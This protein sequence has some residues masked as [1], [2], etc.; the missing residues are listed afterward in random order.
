LHLHHGTLIGILLPH[1]L[2]FN[3]AAAEAEIAGIRHAASIPNAVTTHDWMAGFASDLGLPLKLSELGV[4]PGILPEIA[5][6]AA[7][8]HLSITNPRKASEA[9]YLRLLREAL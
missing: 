3:Q 2:R 1:I 4:G 8:D 6:K 9:D 7:T 5:A